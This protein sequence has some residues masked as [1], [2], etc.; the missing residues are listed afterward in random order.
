MLNSNVSQVGE[1]EYLCQSSINE[2]VTIRK[3][4]EMVLIIITARESSFD[5]LLGLSKVVSGVSVSTDRRQ[6]M[7]AT[8]LIEVGYFFPKRRSN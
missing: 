4:M 7:S 2:T 3:R 5:R 8:L 1:R 6:N